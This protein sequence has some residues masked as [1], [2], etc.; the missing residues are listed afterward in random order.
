MV[1]LG[2]PVPPGFIIATE[3]CVDYLNLEGD[4]K[5]NKLNDQLVY[6]YK[7]AIADLEA[8]TNKKFGGNFSKNDTKAPLL[9]AVRSGAAVA[10]PD[11]MGTVLNVGINDEIVEYMSQT[12]MN[13]KWAYDTYRRFLQMFGNV[14]LNMD[15]K[16]YED[17]LQHARQ[18]RGVEHDSQLEVEDLKEVVK[19]FKLLAS[20][21]DDP[22]EQLHLSI[23]AVFKSW[24]SPRA[25]KYRDIH[26]IPDD[27]GTAVNVM[28][29]VYGSMNDY[30]GSGR[31][32]TRN[33]ITGAKEL[34]GEYLPNAV[35]SVFFQLLTYVC[36]EE[37]IY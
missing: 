6:D 24:N 17:I 10:M 19:E 8:Q 9:L 22:W 14:V 36:T 33:P 28:S 3:C 18:S 11:M 34:Y 30:S 1:R 5:Q 31:A 25:R 32:F 27:M 16:P 15:Q 23:E 2:L 4:Q 35:V 12:Y 29:M 26:N 7:K 20:V 37:M 21:P 13:S